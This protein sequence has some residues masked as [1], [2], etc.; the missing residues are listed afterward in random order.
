MRSKTERQSRVRAGWGASLWRSAAPTALQCSALRCA[1]ELAPRPAGAAL[2]QLRRKCWRSAL[3][4]PPQD[5]RASAPQRRTPACPHPA[6]QHHL[7]RSKRGLLV[8]RHPWC[9]AAGGSQRGRCVWRREAQAWGRRAQRA[10]SS[11]SPQLFER[12]ASRAR[13]EF[14][15]AT[16]SRASQRS[17]RSR[18]PQSAPPPAAACRAARNV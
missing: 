16:P 5:L 7:W 6:L 17:R 2:E 11:C 12:S 1:A 10:S 14:C 3:R 8:A 13:S 4:A 9:C 18:P 15:G